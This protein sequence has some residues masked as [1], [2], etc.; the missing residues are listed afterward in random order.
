MPVEESWEA[1]SVSYQGHVRNS[2]LGTRWTTES[3]T[4]QDVKDLVNF[5][6]QKTV[7]SAIFLGRSLGTAMAAEVAVDMHRPGKTLTDLVFPVACG[8][9]QGRNVQKRTH[10]NHAAL[11]HALER[12]SA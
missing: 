11:V 1:F 3:S 7:K 2:V 10:I 6:W 4:I 12:P 9:S 8:R 5:V